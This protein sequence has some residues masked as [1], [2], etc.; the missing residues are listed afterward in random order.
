GVAREIAGLDRDQAGVAGARADQDA[1]RV[2]GN[3]A[4]SDGGGARVLDRDAGGAAGDPDAGGNECGARHLDAAHGEN[5]GL[6]RD[7]GKR[8]GGAGGAR[9]LGAGGAPGGGWG[10]VGR[11]PRA[12]EGGV[13]GNR[14]LLWV[15]PRRD[16][17]RAGGGDAVDA[18]LDR[19]ERVVAEGMS[20]RAN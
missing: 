18:P 14:A 10:K 17:D 7:A 3:R 19:H 5:G 16:E 20:Y 8:P 11:S 15:G 4:L 2:A 6:D 9:E 13:F 12:V 1:R